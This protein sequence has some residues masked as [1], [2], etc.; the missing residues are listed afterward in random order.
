MQVLKISSAGIGTTVPAQIVSALEQNPSIKYV[1][2]GLGDYAAGVPA[3]IAQAGLAQKVKL[4]VRA[5]APVNYADIRS[6]AISAGITD[7]VVDSGWRDVDALIRLETK[8]PLASAQPVGVTHLITKADVPSANTYYTA[9][10]Y[11]Q[12]YEKAWGLSCKWRMTR[13]SRWRSRAS[14]SATAANPGSSMSTLRFA[15]GRSTRC[16]D[17][18][19]RAS[20]R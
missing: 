17:R 7:E 15:A 4:I 14:P 2:F 9:P 12:V 20:P 3:A 1:V 6:G 19:A 16:W 11:E 13:P 5:V 10:N 8:Q 18:T